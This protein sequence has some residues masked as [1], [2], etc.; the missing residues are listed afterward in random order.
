MSENGIHQPH[1]IVGIDLGTTHSVVSYTRAELGD[2]ETPEVRLLDIA[3]VVAP[4]EVKAQPLLPSFLGS[5][6][7]AVSGLCN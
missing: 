7:D 6:P 2:D 3:Q 4:G 5:S 1:Y